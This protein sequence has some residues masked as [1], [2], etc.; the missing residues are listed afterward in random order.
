MCAR[1]ARDRGGNHWRI[2]YSAF[3]AEGL[4]KR[5]EKTTALAGIDLAAQA[6]DGP[7]RS[8]AEPRA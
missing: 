3:Q 6:G 1:S 2:S 4:V 7:R 8:R 5:F